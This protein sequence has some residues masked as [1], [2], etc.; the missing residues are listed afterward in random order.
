MI[1][2]PNSALIVVD[3]VDHVAIV[4][5]NRPAKYNALTQAMYSDLN[6]VLQSADRDRNIRAVVITGVGTAFSAGND[7]NDFSVRDDCKAPVQRFLRTIAG[8]KVPVIAA[9]NGLAVGVGATLLLHCDLVYA[10]PAATFHFPFV[11]LGLV[12]E[13]ASTLLLA[14]FVGARRSSEILL[15]GQK[16][17]SEEAASWGLINEVSTEPLDRAIAIGHAIAAKAPQAVRHTKS[18]TRSRLPEVTTRMTEEEAFLALQLNSSEFAEVLTAR[19][20]KRQPVFDARGANAT[21]Q[22]NCFYLSRSPRAGSI[23]TRSLD[24]FEWCSTGGS[25]GVPR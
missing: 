14:D 10:D 1:A 5:L 13:A 23:H 24:S 3:Q 15:T 12:P 17:T 22:A 7:L 16:L 2:K 6:E 19:R 20:E 18:L 21:A 8:I 11:D 4:S 25:K 9:V